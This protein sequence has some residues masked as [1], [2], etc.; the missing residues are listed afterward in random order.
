[1]TGDSIAVGGET[2]DRRARRLSAKAAVIDH[3]GNDTGRL[4]VTPDARPQETAGITSAEAVPGAA[5]A[6]AAAAAGGTVIVSSAPDTRVA[7]AAARGRVSLPGFYE[8]LAALSAGA[9]AP[10]PVPADAADPAM[11]TAPTSTVRESPPPTSARA[12]RP[13]VQ[14]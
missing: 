4:A 11:P 7:A 1:M 6:A 14:P 9:I 8:A 3:A 2:T 13:I 12:P 5:Q 10:K